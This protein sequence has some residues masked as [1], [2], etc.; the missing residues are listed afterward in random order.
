M[1]TS[2]TTKL[3]EL[4]VFLSCHAPGVYIYSICFKLHTLFYFVRFVLLHVHVGL[5]LCALVSVFLVIM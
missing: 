5:N 1:L 3:F 4:L 2:R